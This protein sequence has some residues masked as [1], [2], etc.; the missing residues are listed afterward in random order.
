MNVAWVR[1]KFSTSQIIYFVDAHTGIDERLAEPFIPP[2][3][4]VYSAP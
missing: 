3:L 2:I 4:L 1:I